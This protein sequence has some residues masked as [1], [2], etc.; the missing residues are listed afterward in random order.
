MRKLKHRLPS[1]S[2]AEQGC[3]HLQNSE[4][5]GAAGKCVSV[6]AGYA[7]NHLVPSRLAALATPANRAAYERTHDEARCPVCCHLRKLCSECHYDGL[8]A[9]ADVQRVN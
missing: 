4:K 3:V 8:G 9:L 2:C 1:L 5:L 7:R 6:R